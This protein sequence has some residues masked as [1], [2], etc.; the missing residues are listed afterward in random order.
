MNKYKYR[1]VV[2][3]A[4]PK[5]LEIYGEGGSEEEALEDALDTILEDFKDGLYISRDLGNGWKYEMIVAGRNDKF[6]RMVKSE[7]GDHVTEDTKWK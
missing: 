1:F 6:S 7:T 4:M 3:N 5:K 2:D